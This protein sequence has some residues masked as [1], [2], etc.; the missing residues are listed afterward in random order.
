MAKQLQRTY[1]FTPGGAGSG[2]IQIPGKFDLSQ[3]LIITNVTKNQMVYNFADLTYVGTTV[4][5]SRANTTQ[6]PQALGMSDGVTTITLGVSTQ[7]MSSGDILQIFTERTDQAI[8]TRAMGAGTD[9]WERARTSN[10]KSMID[11]DFEYG[12]QPTKW[13]QISAVRGYAGIFEVPGSDLSVTTITTDA[14]YLRPNDLTA[15]SLI[16]VNTQIPHNLTTGTAITV[17]TLESTVPS[18][19]LAQGTFI[20]NAVPTSTSLNYYAKGKVG[21]VQ[22]TVINSTYTVVRQ[23][24]FYTGASRTDLTF[25]VLSGG[26]VGS[27]ATIAATFATDH[28]FTPGQGIM[29]VVTSDNGTNN[30]SYAQGPFYLTTITSPTTFNFLARSA[31]GAI[32]GGTITGF[33]YA[34]SDSFYVHRA[35]DGGVQLGTGGPS[36]GASAVRQSKK[37]IRYQSGKSI[38]YNTGLLLAPNYQLRF[39]TATN[40]TVGSSIIGI[41]D[42]EDHQ[43][44]SGAVIKLEN[45]VS[46]GYNGVYTVASIIDSRTF[47]VT[48]TQTLST[49]TAIMGTPCFVSLI[50]W[51]GSTVRAGTFDEQNGMF[52]QYDGQTVALGLRVSTTDLGGLANISPDSTYTTATNA[53]WL[54]QLIAGDRVVLRGMTHHVSRV[55]SDNSMYING[56]WRPATASTGIRIMKTLEKIIPQSQW[57]MDRCDG[58]GSVYNPS[59]Y[60]LL[61]NKMQMAGIQWTWYGAGFIDF[62]LRGPDGNYITVHRLR[63]NNVNNEAYMRTGNMPV[64][65]EVV[66]EGV[67]TG[68]ARDMGSLDTVMTVTDV[69]FFPSSGMVYVDNELISYTGITTSTNT[70]NNL[71]RATPINQFVGNSNRTFQAGGAVSHYA[72]AGTGV[73]LFGQTAAPNISHW[74]SAFLQDGGFDEDRGYLFNYGVTNVQISVKKTTLFAIRL[75][76]SVSNSI[77]GDLGA[78]DLINRA[79]FLLQA[80][81]ISAGGST[82]VNTAIVIEGVLNPINHPISS[83]ITWYSLNGSVASSPVAN[84]QPSFSQVAAGTAMTFVN[85]SLSVTGANIA[86]SSAAAGS[87]TLTITT[88]GAAAQ[89]QVGDV[90]IPQASQATSIAGGTFIQAISSN[91]ITLNNPLLGTLTIF[92][93]SRSTFALPG[94]TIF[95]FIGSQAN[96]DVLDLSSL[97]ELTNTPM[98]GRSCYPNGPDALFINAYLTQGTPIYTNVLLRW[99]EAQA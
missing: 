53:R 28:G 68:L 98:G 11:A 42:L 88:G 21:T 20:I 86:C 33:V 81:E 80:L 9:A 54:T 12:L 96:R 23:G 67:R 83:N 64:R 87:T 75:A 52:W 93:A 79:Q 45:V 39:V 77:P 44:Q 36:Y 73:L 55:V 2:T 15:E 35:Y 74:G 48:A 19:A 66:N 41:T 8:L 99:A 18:Y 62:M 71:V 10:P 49:T 17:S 85:Q 43:F 65:Y 56:D 57:N 59:G 82:N 95:S 46:S 37:Y 16:T 3:L 38:N 84:G 47:V 30:H 1:V 4:A 94:E 14:N 27:T 29:V 58:S 78:R 92:T 32:T 24:G 26:T 61:V 40:T 51:Y 6:F 90:I 60:N 70:L 5:F 63:N 22:D 72:N 25:S 97:K 89:L 91:F 13:Q 31:V 76:P 69:T 34:R 50:N 7:G